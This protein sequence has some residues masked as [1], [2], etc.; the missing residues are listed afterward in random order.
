MHCFQ[1]DD[2]ATIVV[3]SPHVR[4]D[5]DVVVR[6]RVAATKCEMDL[7]VEERVV[8]H[9]CARIVGILATFAL[10]GCASSPV[11]GVPR[12][13]PD[14]S[15]PVDTRVR[16]TAT[17]AASITPDRRLEIYREL[18]RSF[19]RPTRGQA[20]WIDP[21]PLSHTRD[22]ASDSLAVEDDAW[23]DEM[24][25][26]IGLRRV[27]VLDVRDDECR[28]RPGGVLRFSAPYALS[29][30]GDSAIV[31]ARYSS[32]RAGEPAVPRAGFE[33]EFRLARRD[34]AWRIVSKRTVASP[35]DG[36]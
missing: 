30:A 34:G 29:S 32:V 36:R 35:Q 9:S 11:R 7:C 26:T 14:D 31:F 18:V 22:V 4:V 21:Q 27:C 2:A 13:I 1:F 12:P 20:R 6:R 28:G 10:L 19:F 8:A 23:A 5:G 25:R 33:M 15:R 16:G 17:A 3:V 24:V